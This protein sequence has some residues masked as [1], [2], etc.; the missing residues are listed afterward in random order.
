MNGLWP[1]EHGAYA[2]LGFP[3]LTG[4]VYAHGQAGAVAFATA[5]IAGFLAHEPL[6]VITGVR[7]T[8]LRESLG[9]L[10]R[11]RLA[12]LLVV[13]AAGLVGAVVLAPARAWIGAAVPASFALL[14]LPVLGTRRMK[15]LP[16]EVIAVAAF[17]TGVVP[18]GLCGP[19]TATETAFAAVAWFAAFVPAIFTVHAIKAALRRRP[20]ER[21][22]LTAAPAVAAL[23]LGAVIVGGLVWP[24]ARE[25]FGAVV[26]VT[27]ILALS[28]RPPHPR[29]LKRVGWALV[30]ANT[31]AFGLI[32]V[33]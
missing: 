2:Q 11:R 22:L 17:S 13:A 7:G 25:L 33:L 4:I 27:V 30:A 32:L 9:S 5:A 21:W 19:A 14:L 10:A 31:L 6:A 26:P 24:D 1:R 12:L 20:G 8:R 23:V 29:H 15:S 18:L 28:L 3:L 16:A